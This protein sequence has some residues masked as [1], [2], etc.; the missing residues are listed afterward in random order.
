M[1]IR[2]NGSMK[3]VPR[4]QYA[5][6]YKRRGY[7]PVVKTR[8]IKPA[9]KPPAET[10]LATVTPLVETPSTKKHAQQENDHVADS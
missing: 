3:N 2:R 8:K 5:K 10:E 6:V 9:A 7:K 4:D 1:W